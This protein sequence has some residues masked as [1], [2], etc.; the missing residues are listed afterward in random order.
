M[1]SARPRRSL[2][3]SLILTLSTALAPE[4]RADLPR[5][6]EGFEAR[7]VATVPAV[8]FPCQLATAPDGALYVAEDPMD[9]VGPYEASD[10]RILVFREGRDPVVFADG[11]RAI[12]GMAWHDG[13]LYVS[14]MPFLTVLRDDDR[15]GKAD[16][17]EDL[18]KDL[19]PTAN[20]GLNDHIVSGL[21]FGM[22]GFLYI[23]V[24][25]KGIPHATGPDGRTIQ[26]KGG[27]VVRCR[28]DGT[29]I[30]VVSSGTRNHLDPN[31]DDRDNIFTYDNTD[32]G[33]GW[34]TRVTHHI[35]SGYYGYPY[36][37]HGR[38]DRMLPRM[39]EYGGGSPCGALIYKED[40]WPEKYRG[41][42]LWAEWGKGKVQAFRFS[43]SGSTF[44]VAETFDFAAP[45]GLKAFR[46]IDL[47]LSYDGKTLYVADWNYGGWGTKQ[48]KVGRVFAVSYKGEPI[49]TRPRGKDSD[50]VGAQ[51]KQLAHPSFNERMRAQEAIVKKGYQASYR[52]VLR[53]LRDPK[54]DPLARRHLIWTYVAIA[55]G[56]EAPAPILEGLL[57]A[58]EADLRAQA[59]RAVG[60]VG[61]P[62][63]S[64]ALI[65]LLKDPEPTVRLQVAIALGRIKERGA[66]LA[67]LPSLAEDDAYIAFAARQALRRIDDWEAAAS[68]LDADDP[69]KVRAGVLA[70][71]ELQYDVDAAAALASYAG[72]ADRPV[73]ERAL[74]LKYLAQGHRKEKPWDGKWWGTRPTRSK[75]PA[76]EVEWEG[77]P[78]VLGAIRRELTDVLPPMRI[79]AIAAVVETS[80]RPSL[81]TLHERFRLEEVPDVRRELARALGAMGDK[82]ALPLLI[83]AVR[84]REAPD[85]VR[86]AALAAVEQIG[87]DVAITALVELLDAGDLAAGRR[88]GVIA[89][90]GRF[91]AK[92]AVATL[93]RSL[94][95]PEPEVRE[96]SAEALGKIGQLQG[97]AAPLRAKLD[98]PAT[99]V[100]EAAVTALGMLGDREAIPALIKAADHEETRYEATLALAAMPDML[101]LPVY[102]RGLA[103]KSPDL[104]KAAAEALEKVRDEA[105]PALEE[106]ARKRQLPAA[107]VPELRKVF[108]V[109]SPVTAWRVLGPFDS[110]DKPPVEPGQPIDATRTYVGL[111]KQPVVWKEVQA[112]DKG[113]VDLAPLFP[114]AR[115]HVAA[116]AYA[117]AESPEA[118]E[119]R[120][121]FDRGQFRTLWLNGRKVYDPGDNRTPRP[122]ASG[123]DV[124]L[125]KGANRILLQSERRSDG[126]WRF[127]VAVTVPGDY[128]FLKAPAASADPEAL[129]AFAMKE[130]GDPEHGRALFLDLKGLGCVKCHAVGKQGGSVGPGLSSVGA[131]YGRDE[132]INSVLFPSQRISSGY[133]P[134]VV[135]VAD[136]RVL[137]GIVKN[138][139]AD[140]L[141]IE[142]ADA[143]LVR[144]PKADIEERRTSDVS[145]MPNGLV[146]GLRPQDFADLIAFLESLKEPPAQPAANG[147][148]R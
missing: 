129:R 124:K 69:P 15:D 75:P 34:W 101:A 61:R 125:A 86:E 6:P 56:R 16:H 48:E 3:A 43:P 55:R 96:A 92:A 146:D 102:L 148:G 71:M 8:E 133:E 38:P 52:P 80:D 87:T 77:T 47:A 128:A 136:G 14:H 68:G 111:D 74:A 88:V 103:D 67:L 73:E 106:M 33:D 141:E 42:G 130:K 1:S 22:D 37:Y 140:A 126:A 93:V 70:A 32:D 89:A 36:D 94:D 81:E 39:S 98:D 9:Q 19:G 84:D 62:E 78:I 57:T 66:V 12:F 143:K 138:D 63:D 112:D 53:A 21:Q 117:E 79:A 27:G 119:A 91:K 114:E 60:L 50:P 135:A 122:R 142:D 28:P 121:V 65:P 134:V 104:R 118:R 23:A 132:L 46:P 113:R 64:K 49:E 20:R 120:L 83:A 137:T 13:R 24:G 44:K 7:L 145:L 85:P 116:F 58:P 10:G 18:F 109:P 59:A 95:G 72:H 115:E 110:R 131:Q 139:T 97:A 4:A 25:D 31:L 40:A 35:D 29:G 99:R 144:I 54:A 30:E 107:I 82:E 90:L 76:K 108:T 11:F 41:I 147:G 51:I 26:L 100:R 127:A 105:A 5:V 45:D 123:L 2:S 17:R